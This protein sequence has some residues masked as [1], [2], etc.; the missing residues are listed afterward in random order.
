M[1]HRVQVYWD[2]TKARRSRHASGLQRVANNLRDALIANGAELTPV[3][4]D[5]RQQRFVSTRGSDIDPAESHA[6]GS[7][8]FFTAELFSECERPGLQSWLAATPQRTVALFHD[9]IPLRMPEIT[10]PQSV[11][12]H[13][14]YLEDLCGFQLVL[15]VSHQSA[16]DLRAFWRWKGVSRPPPVQVVSC[17]SDFD[18]RPRVL[19]SSEP[20]SDPPL[21]L[22][23]AIL[24]PRKNQSGLLDAC[25]LLWTEGHRFRLV[26]AGR[27][28]P[29]YGKPIL[30]RIR[31]LQSRGFALEHLPAPT[32]QQ[33]GPL[34]EQAHLCVF[35]SLAEGNG[36]PVLEALWRGVPVV[37]SP[38]PA[39][40][41]WS[42]GHGVEIVDPLTPN[43]LAETLR[44][45]LSDPDRYRTLRNQ[46][47]KAP[48]LSWNEA[49]QALLE[50][51]GISKRGSG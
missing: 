30:R 23:T 47:A 6:N 46:T 16:S 45:L 48:L 38:I 4:W 32:D 42:G 22:C 43:A 8:I 24:E 33:L 1:T 21:W 41:E 29:H 51:C 5:G 11:Q 34:Y 9:A 40:R 39:A 27:V 25:E 37:A 12:R 2:C 15:A 18:G 19:A 36:L 49:A 3:H 50:L 28:N 10:W 14:Y 7:G 17:G 35:P 44:T 13:P 31:A 20:D 26:L